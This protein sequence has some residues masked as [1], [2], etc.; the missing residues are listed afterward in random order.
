[1]IWSIT[2]SRICSWV[3]SGLCCVETTTVST[4]TGLAPQNSMVTWL[5]LS[6]RSQGTSLAKRAAVSRAR[7]RWAKAMGSGISSAVSLQA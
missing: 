2:Y 4:R 7:M 1:M 6:G 5:L 3:T